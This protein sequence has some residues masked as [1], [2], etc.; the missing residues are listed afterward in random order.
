MAHTMASMP[1]AW[2]REGEPVPTARMRV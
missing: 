2:W 1:H